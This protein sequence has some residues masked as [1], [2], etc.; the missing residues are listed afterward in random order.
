MENEPQ[1]ILEVIPRLGLSEDE[2]QRVVDSACKENPKGF[3]KVMQQIIEDLEESFRPHLTSP[4]L[5]SSSHAQE[6]AETDSTLGVK[7]S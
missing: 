5:P 4:N 2:V 7:D 3:S 1:R 6:T